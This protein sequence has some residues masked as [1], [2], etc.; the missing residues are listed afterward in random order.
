M[1]K[2]SIDI[3]FRKS[4]DPMH[5][6]LCEIMIEI[7]KL[8]INN[9]R[10]KDENKLHLNDK[11]AKSKKGKKGRTNKQHS[12]NQYAAIS[13]QALYTLFYCDIIITL[14]CLHFV[15]EH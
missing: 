11:N 13:R 14:L 7:N 1:N 10:T 15:Q 9:S 8:C 2:N 4:T 12:R 3:K 6:T 5:C